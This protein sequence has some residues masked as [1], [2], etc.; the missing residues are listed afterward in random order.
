MSVPAEEVFCHVTRRI[1]RPH[2]GDLGLQQFKSWQ[3]RAHCKWPYTMERCNDVK[4]R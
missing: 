2:R 3:I 4:V 1:T